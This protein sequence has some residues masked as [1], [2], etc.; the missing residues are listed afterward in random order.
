MLQT[1]LTRD[2]AMRIFNKTAFLFV[3]SRHVIL[4]LLLFS[5]LVATTFLNIATF[6]PEGFYGTG[7]WK[8]E[9]LLYGLY[10][11]I[12]APPNMVYSRGCLVT[13]LIIG[14]LGNLEITVR[15]L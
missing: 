14:A 3:V 9:G 15:F 13:S 8:K 1:N 4:M 10:M 2:I 6:V 12:P 5:V 7:L 11:L